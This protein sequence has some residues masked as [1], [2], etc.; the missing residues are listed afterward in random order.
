MRVL[1]WLAL[2]G[3]L[4]GPAPAAADQLPKRAKL[5]LDEFAKSKDRAEL[6]NA[7]GT[8]VF[9][10]YLAD[11]A[12]DEH[13][14][15]V[16]LGERRGDLQLGALT[17]RTGSTSIVARPGISEFLSAAL[18]SGA[19]ARKTDDTSFTL[20][21]NALMLSQVLRGQIPRGCGSLDDACRQ[22]P[23]R[24]LRGLSGSATFAVGNSGAV[25][26]GA[27]ADEAAAIVD[28][29]QL[30]AL[31]IRYE[32]LVRERNVAKVQAALEEART[33]LQTAA[34]AFL[35]KQAALET[36]IQQTM[37]AGWKDETLKLLDAETSPAGREAVLLRR[38]QTLR[39]TVE[40]SAEI[41]QLRAAAFKE[42]RVYLV[43][44]NKL[45]AEKLYRKALTVDYLHE[46]P[47]GQ[48]ALE[49]VRVVFSTPLGRKLE[50][51]FEVRAPKGAF[52][53]NAGVSFFNPQVT[54]GD[55]W[56]VRDSQFSAALDWTP[57]QT[58]TVRAT[59]TAAY[60][61]QYMVANGVLKF[62][63]TAITPGGAAI[64]LPKTATE[65]L[66]TKGD[67]HVGQFR[68]SIPAAQGVR[69]PLAVTYSSRTELVKADKGF[70]QGHAG[71]S[72][73][74]GALK[75]LLLRQ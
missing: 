53:M 38:Y 57:N 46:R 8:D 72:Y 65:L 13:P 7:V 19:V 45:L 22:G 2:A 50:D 73:D 67:I 29:N 60:Y 70:W 9:T 3:V 15:R 36:R 43:A 54:P 66:N 24:W 75:Q 28:D 48:P 26:T 40:A 16:E 49:Q 64:P 52:T 33:A 17:G 1:L 23:G 41:T 37:D 4:G 14:D 30:T 6:L 59:F 58:G 21:V 74:L 42:Y 35:P 34:A 68:V 61:F 69:F 63:K 55:G 44:Q 62:D 11:R 71:V 20:N 10:D 12:L 31:S 5:H 27:N 47:T 39:A 25:V 18:E 32:L 56:K 51:G